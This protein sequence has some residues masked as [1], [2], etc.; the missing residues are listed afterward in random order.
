MNAIFSTVPCKVSETVKKIIRTQKKWSCFW[1]W[2]YKRNQ[3]FISWLGH[4]GSFL[5]KSIHIS[6]I[7]SSCSSSSSPF[8]IIILLSFLLRFRHFRLHL[9]YSATLIFYSHLILKDPKS[10]F[11]PRLAILLSFTLSFCSKRRL[12][13]L[14]NLI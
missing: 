4:R 7:S 1:F 13:V 11:Y 8:S 3:K 12:I 10:I 5:L 9:S 14:I 2:E 6:V